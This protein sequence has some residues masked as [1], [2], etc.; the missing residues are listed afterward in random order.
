MC[1]ELVGFDR[2]EDRRQAHDGLFIGVLE[3]RGW[4]WLAGHGTR[5]SA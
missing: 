3:K 1:P 5:F 2:L 4:Q